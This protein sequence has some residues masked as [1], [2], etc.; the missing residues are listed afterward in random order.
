MAQVIRDGFETI[1]AAPG[2]PTRWIPSLV[3]D[4]ATDTYLHPD[5]PFSND[6]AVRQLIRRAR[7]HV[8]WYEQHMDRKALE[9]LSE[10]LAPMASR[11][12]AHV[13]P[14]QPVL[15]DQEGFRAFL[16]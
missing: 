11:G 6:L 3:P 4:R 2:E 14:G 9:V 8:F 7:R 15:E 16:D 10:E 5:R 12:S 13:G 1:G